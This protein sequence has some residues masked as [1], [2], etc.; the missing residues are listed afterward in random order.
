MGTGLSRSLLGFGEQWWVRWC[1]SGG[2]SGSWSGGGRAA[3]I[4]IM[5]TY[6]GGGS[7]SLSP[8]YHLGMACCGAT[9]R[10]SMAAVQASAAMA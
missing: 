7:R 5:L 8:L 4:I 10:G 1:L 9:M 6:L 3:P 2:G